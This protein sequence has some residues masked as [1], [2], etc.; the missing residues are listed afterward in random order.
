MWGKMRQIL[1]AVVGATALS[2]A[3]IPNVFAADMAAPAPM[4]SKAPMA[5][6]A[7]SWTGLYV[8]ANGGYGWGQDAVN[9][10]PAAGDA[11]L[12]FADGVVPRSVS[13]KPA[14]GLAGGQIGYNWQ[15]NKIWVVGLEADLDWAGI[16]GS[17]SASLP[18]VPGVAGGFSNFAT[19]KLASLGTVRARFGY[20]IDNALFY[21]TGGL[22]Y[23]STSLQT[24][25]IGVGKCGPVGVCATASSTQWMAGWTAGAGFE[26]AFASMWSLKA[27]YLYYD[28][29]SRSQTQFDPADTFGAPYFSSSVAFR[30]DIVRVGLNYHLH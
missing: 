26:W 5:P 20:A 13:T 7:Y 10:A 16:N 4:Y 12:L 6:P 2:I 29:G 25:V 15:W 3:C 27:E 30:G 17:G 21:A 1:S 19:Q 24:S 18:T 22:A 8:G 23:G 14:G 11:A 9:F 28:L